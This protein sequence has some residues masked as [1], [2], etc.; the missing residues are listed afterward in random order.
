M[1][2]FAGWARAIVLRARGK[3]T[4]GSAAEPDAPGAL[5]RPG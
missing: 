3:V 4:T 2:M 5:G 1:A